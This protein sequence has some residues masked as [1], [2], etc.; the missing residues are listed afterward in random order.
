[1]SLDNIQLS[2]FLV[3]HLYKKSLVEQVQQ[4]KTATAAEEQSIAFLGKNEKGIL[5]IADEK[6]TA[7]LTD[8][9][10]ALLVGI[11]TAC[12]LSLADIALVNFDKNRDMEYGQLMQQFKPVFVLMFGVSPGQLDFPLSFPHFQLQ[13]YNHQTY[14][15]SP[16]LKILAAEKEQKKEL[17]TSLQKHFFKP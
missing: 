14:L 16:A 7:F 10:L 15:C 8:A 11:L 17:W 6:D 1:M 9:D 2:P 3:Q 5:I 12:K 4:K 13:Q